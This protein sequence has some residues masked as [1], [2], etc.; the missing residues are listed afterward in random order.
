M[1][2]RNL[3]LEVI[4]A[5]VEEKES[6]LSSL[7]PEMQELLR[8]LREIEL[9]ERIRNCMDRLIAGDIDFG[10]DFPPEE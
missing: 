7:V 8:R 4:K 9:N 5:W 10:E 6:P 2:T 3:G 1:E